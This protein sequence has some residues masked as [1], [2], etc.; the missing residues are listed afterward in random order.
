MSRILSCASGFVV[1]NILSIWTTDMCRNFHIKFFR[2][3]RTGDEE[4]ARMTDDRDQPETH[5][6][7]SDILVMATLHLVMEKRIGNV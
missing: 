2:K 7:T 4:K 3:F 5:F 6:K 1:R